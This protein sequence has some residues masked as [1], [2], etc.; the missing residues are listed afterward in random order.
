MATMPYAARRPPRGHQKQER[1]RKPFESTQTR[2]KTEV[3]VKARR[4]GG[5][6][7]TLLK[8]G[9]PPSPRTP[10]PLSQNLYKKTGWMAKTHPGRQRRRWEMPSRSGLAEGESL[11]GGFPA[12]LQ[13][14]D[15]QKESSP[16][17]LRVEDSRRCFRQEDSRQH[18]RQKRSRQRF[19]RDPRPRSRQTISRRHCGQDGVRPVPPHTA[20]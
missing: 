17:P 13:A 16:Q 1:R 10:R 12:A 6:K 11:T 20:A 7:E 15:F 19:R 3:P 8:K 4:P 14:E 18:S 9:S 5:R 2:G